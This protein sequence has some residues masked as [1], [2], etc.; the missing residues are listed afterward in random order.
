MKSNLKL[1]TT[2][3]AIA[4]VLFSV[5]AFSQD[6]AKFCFTSK[7]MDKWIGAVVNGKAYKRAYDSC[8]TIMKSDSLTIE[9]FVV[10]D[11][12]SQAYEKSLVKTLKKRTFGQRFYQGTTIGV[13]I[14]WGV[15]E[16]KQLL[17]K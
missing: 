7:E 14:A 12:K 16:L 15:R 4:F 2:L 17:N 13:A 8:L 5:T 10:L 6:S 9:A 1:I 11:K 3:L